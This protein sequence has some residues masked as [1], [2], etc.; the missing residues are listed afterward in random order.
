MSA[1]PSSLWGLDGIAPAR[2]PPEADVEL[3]R[4]RSIPVFSD[5]DDEEVEIAHIAA[6]RAAELSGQGRARRRAHRRPAPGRVVGE[7]GER[8]SGAALER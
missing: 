4:L 1:R 6:A 7:M 5:H 3:A 8:A 2:R